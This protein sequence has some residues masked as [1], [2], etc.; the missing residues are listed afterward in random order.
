M[1]RMTACILLLLFTLSLSGCTSTP[2]SKEDTTILYYIRSAYQYHSD[3]NVIVGEERA[4]AP[5]QLTVEKLLDLYLDGPVGSDLTLPIPQATDLVD[6]QEYSGLVEITLTDTEH[7]LTDAQ[8]SLAC[9]CL[10]KTLLEN[11]DIIQISFF[12][13]DRTMTVERENYLITDGVGVTE[14][15]KE[16]NP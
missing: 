13:G 6:I 15:R 11:T 7:A 5:E 4:L 14:I 16:A 8:F 1:K 12:S 3:E 10:G 9:V 2:E